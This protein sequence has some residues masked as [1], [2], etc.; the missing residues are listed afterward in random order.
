VRNHNL[1]IFVGS[2]KIRRIWGTIRTCFA[3]GFQYSA[4]LSDIL[5]L[6]VT[7]AMLACFLRGEAR[8]LAAEG[9][10]LRVPLRLDVGNLDGPSLRSR[11]FYDPG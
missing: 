5:S 11:F 1:Q 4:D 9:G 8:C 7:T 3:S 2:P 10:E 6:R